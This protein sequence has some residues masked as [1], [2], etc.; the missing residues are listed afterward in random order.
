MWCTLYV[1]EQCFLCRPVVRRM[2]YVCVPAEWKGMTARCLALIAAQVENLQARSHKIL[3][4]FGICHQHQPFFHSPGWTWL[5]E[6]VP[7]CACFLKLWTNYIHF[8]REWAQCLGMIALIKQ[9]ASSCWY[10]DPGWDSSS[11]LS[12]T[13]WVHPNFLF[14]S[15]PFLVVPLGM[16]SL[17]SL[18]Y[19]P[20]LAPPASNNAVLLRLHRAGWRTCQFERARWGCTFVRTTLTSSHT[21]NC[22]LHFLVYF[23][24]HLSRYGRSSD[25]LGPET[26]NSHF[27]T[28]C[29]WDE[30]FDHENI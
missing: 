28:S 23:S 21:L 17:L 19:S 14:L 27:L 12:H 5:G 15:F 26:V 18:H 24:D 4:L 1:L 16:C 20:S 8:N 30:F 7:Q 3:H 10:S 29:T 11:S 9:N 25:P 13:L 6:I 22:L 2:H